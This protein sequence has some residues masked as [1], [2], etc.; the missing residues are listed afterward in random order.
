MLDFEFVML[1]LRDTLS[2]LELVELSVEF[3]TLHA[4]IQVSFLIY[5]FRTISGV[6]KVLRGS[7]ETPQEL[8]QFIAEIVEFP[9]RM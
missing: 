2:L 1:S 8:L 6:S 7:Y 4:R 3:S 5:A 9:C